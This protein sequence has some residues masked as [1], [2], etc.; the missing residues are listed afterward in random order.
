MSHQLRGGANRL[1]H[2]D[3]GQ[4]AESTHN[5]RLSRPLGRFSSPHS[6][7]RVIESCCVDRIS[8]L[9][10]RVRRRLL[11]SIKLIGTSYGA[12]IST[13]Y[14]ALPLTRMNEEKLDCISKYE[15][16]LIAGAAC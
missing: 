1:D 9:S 5:E 4:R 13:H 8:R 15:H 14:N 16:I 7:V 3:S 12:F 11:R 10:L 2:V 6:A